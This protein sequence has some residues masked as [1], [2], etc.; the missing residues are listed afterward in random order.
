VLERSAAL[1]R[2]EYRVALPCRQRAHDQRRSQLRLVC[3]TE[4]ELHSVQEL[5]KC[6]YEITGTSPALCMPLPASSD[7]QVKREEL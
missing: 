5:E 3:G 6:E 7:A 1:R 2:C 4:N